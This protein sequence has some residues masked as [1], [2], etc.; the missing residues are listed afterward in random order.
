MPRKPKPN[1]H[2]QAVKKYNNENTKQYQL[3]LNFK[4]DADLIEKM[5]SVPNKLGYLK[6]LIRDDIA[7]KNPAD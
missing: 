6:Q 7:K 3:R 5:E 2:T 4:T 1:A